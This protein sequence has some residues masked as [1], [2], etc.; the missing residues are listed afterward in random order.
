M[1]NKQA[2]KRKNRSSEED[3]PARKPRTVRHCVG[4]EEASAPDKASPREDDE[5][6][7]G[8]QDDEESMPPVFGVQVPTLSNLRWTCPSRRRLKK[9]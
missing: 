1:Q 9:K 2:E 6:K 7:S 4:L 8:D 5:E 3:K